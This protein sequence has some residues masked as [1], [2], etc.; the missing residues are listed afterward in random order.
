MSAFSERY[1]WIWNY[2]KNSTLLGTNNYPRTTTS[3]YDILCRNTKYT[4]H[5]QQSCLSNLMIHRTIRYSQGT[6]GGNLQKSHDIAVKK[7][8]II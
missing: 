7:K 4:R 8:D 2:L 6:M 1:S 3:A 5:Q